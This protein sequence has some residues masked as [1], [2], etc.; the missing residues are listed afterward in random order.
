TSGS[1]LALSGAG[2]HMTGERIHTLGL[3]SRRSN[4]F[5]HYIAIKAHVHPEAPGSEEA[6]RAALFVS[7]LPLG[8]DERS[9]TEIFECFGPVS[10]AVLH[11]LKR[12]GIVVFQSD[13]G[14]VAAIRY[15]S[16]SQVLEYDGARRHGAAAD[17]DGAE[18]PV[19]VKG[20]WRTS[21]AVSFCHTMKGALGSPAQGKG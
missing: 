16:R 9:L 19:G 5:I 1:E 18:E 3:R 11:P 15:A 13:V 14:R 6:V 8:V 21:R 4:P 7:G 12:S 10:Q 2:R 20:A 17:K